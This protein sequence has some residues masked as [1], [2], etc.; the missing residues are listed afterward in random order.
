M[1]DVRLLFET[2]SIEQLTD[3]GYLENHLI[4]KLGL[5]NEI[6]NEQPRELTPYYGTGHQLKIWQY[7]NQ[8]SK[9]L[10]FLSQYAHHI[11]SYMEIGCRHGGTFVTH[12]E[13]LRKL[14]PAFKVAVAVDLI[15]CPALLQQ[16]CAFNASAEFHQ[17]NSTSKEFAHYLEGK[18]YDVIFI[19]GDHSFEGVSADALLTRDISNIQVFH[20]ITSDACPGVGKYWRSMKNTES[21]TYNFYEFTDQYDSVTGTFLGIGVA[22]R[23]TWITNP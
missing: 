1:Q 5:N 14:N 18:F 8:F 3:P 10:V 7:P 13:Y 21:K 16:Y 15:E 6:L 4:L 17:G 2:C 19:D 20:D 12:C 11:N 23:K 22:V 9:Y